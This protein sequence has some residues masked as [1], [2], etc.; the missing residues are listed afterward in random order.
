MNKPFP[1]GALTPHSVSPR[2]T[3]GA[4]A[5]CSL[6]LFRYRV[7]DCPNCDTATSSIGCDECHGGEVDCGC[8]DCSRVAP[9]NDDGVCRKC[10]DAGELPSAD[11]AA[12]YML[13]E[14]EH[15]APGRV[16]V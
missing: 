2:S 12:K 1:I 9:L 4:S 6:K 10:F 5:S 13:C 11:F 7:A 14:V 15:L 3:E 8:A 16:V